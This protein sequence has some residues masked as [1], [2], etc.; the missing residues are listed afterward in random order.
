MNS[1]I[2]AWHFTGTQLRDG[3]PVPPIGEW[4]VHAG[5]LRICESGLHAS[6]LL[7]DAM[8]YAPDR[9]LHLVEVA[10]DI[11]HGTD[12][13]VA[14]RRRIL[15]T[16][17]PRRGT[18]VRL[19]G[20]ALALAVWLAEPDN[21]AAAD[22]AG[23]YITAADAGDWAAAAA[24]AAAAARG[25]A[26]AAVTAAAAEAAVTAAAAAAAA[27][28]RAAAAAATA[29]AVWAGEA[30]AATASA[31]WA[32]EAAAATAA[33]AAIRAARGAA[34]TMPQVAA[35]DMPRAASSAVRAAARASRSAATSVVGAAVVREHMEA[36]ARDLLA[37]GRA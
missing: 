10:G 4:L 21:E 15:R 12:K 6:L 27:A 3:R 36:R 29:S 30:A 8:Q 22:A 33:A 37:P 34:W 16:W 26:V 13:L 31:V 18:Y 17:R 19:A 28:A 2:P 1:T 32:A 5:P 25:A 23:A 35:S 11:V 14:R 9:H 24:A 20:E 7:L